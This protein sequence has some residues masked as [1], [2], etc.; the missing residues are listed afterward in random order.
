MTQAKALQNFLDM[1][2]ILPMPGV[3]DPISFNG[4]ATTAG[5]ASRIAILLRHFRTD[6]KVCTIRRPESGATVR[7]VLRIVSFE[8]DMLHSVRILCPMI[9]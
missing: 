2:G 6:T 3:F 7:V 8:E 5:F 4:S 1:P 9:S